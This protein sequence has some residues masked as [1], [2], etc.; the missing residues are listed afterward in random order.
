MRG[1][2]VAAGSLPLRYGKLKLDGFTNFSGV[3]PKTKLD[4]IRWR[5][6]NSSPS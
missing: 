2:K 5:K 4:I 1:S 6:K 3:G